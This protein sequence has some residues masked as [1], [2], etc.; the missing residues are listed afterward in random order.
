MTW[1]SPSCGVVELSELRW[2]GTV[3]VVVA[4]DSLS[5]GGGGQSELWWHGTPG[6]GAFLL[7]PSPAFWTEIEREEH[8]LLERPVPE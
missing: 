8:F 1:D 6:E 4:G 2:C 7:C 5:C 3:R